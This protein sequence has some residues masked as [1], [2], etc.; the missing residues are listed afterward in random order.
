MEKT[1]KIAIEEPNIEPLNWNID[2]AAAIERTA[3]PFGIVNDMMKESTVSE[4]V[5]KSAIDMDKIIKESNIGEIIK[6]SNASPSLAERVKAR[7]RKTRYQTMQGLI[8]KLKKGEQL[9]DQYEEY[10]QPIQRIPPI[11][12]E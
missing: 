9:Y 3:E 12:V 11:K 6:E 4:I 10:I 2:S 1:K 7:G 5:D 8:D